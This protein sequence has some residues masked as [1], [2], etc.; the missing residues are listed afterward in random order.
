MPCGRIGSGDA[1]PDA[2]VLDE[3]E[4]YEQ[5]E[6]TEERPGVRHLV[7]PPPEDEQS[8]LQRKGRRAQRHV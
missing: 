2:Q 4:N 5:Q 7:A 6:V 8:A 3:Q 1:S